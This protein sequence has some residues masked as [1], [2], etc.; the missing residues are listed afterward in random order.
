MKILI[1][2]GTGFI[3]QGLVQHWS[4]HT[5]HDVTLLS[6]H[7]KN[8]LHWDEFNQAPTT[9][10]T[11]FDL[12]INLC[13][14][15][16]GQRRWS[17]RRKQTILTSRIQPTQTLATHLA[18][19]G[20]QAPRWF[21]ASAIGIYGIQLNHS[22]YLPPSLDEQTDLSHPPTCFL[23]KVGT[24]WE[25]A[26]QPAIQAGVPT[27]LLRFGVVLAKHDGALPQIARP[28]WWGLGGRIGSGC[29]PFSW[30]SL[31]D[32]CRAIDFLIEHPHVQGPI[33]L[34]A[35]KCIRQIEFAHSLA[36][37]L[38]RPSCFTL[39]NSIV[40]LLFGQMGE[41]LLLSGQHVIPSRLLDLGFQFALPDIDSALRNIYSTKKT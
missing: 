32:L 7:Q 5:T 30:I 39:P 37:Q 10:L 20:N 40:Q 28:F 25:A 15:N 16:I 8:T 24:Q 26:T 4:S 21:N 34:V 29:Q 23:A 36:H 11:Q 9:W 35:P 6:R 38:H 2:G 22:H 1:A 12:V 31:K 19:L 27:V 3:G 33:N 14:A 18:K 17:T 13:G 41:E